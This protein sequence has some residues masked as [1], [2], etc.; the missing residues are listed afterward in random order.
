MRNSPCRGPVGL[1]LRTKGVGVSGETHP[2]GVRTPCWGVSSP[3]SEVCGQSS[4][5]WGL[6]RMLA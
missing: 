4:A 6:M 5:S 3:P 1:A 2:G